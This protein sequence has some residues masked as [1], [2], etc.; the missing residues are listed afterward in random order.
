MGVP[1]VTFTADQLRAMRAT[2]DEL[3]ELVR[4]RV[5]GEAR[6]WLLSLDAGERELLA[7]RER[8]AILRR[9]AA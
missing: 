3:V 2:T 4:G 5:A 9:C 8:A 7:E 1:G 6:R